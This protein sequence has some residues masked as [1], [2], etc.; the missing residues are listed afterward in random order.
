M[1]KEVINNVSTLTGRI[2]I[3]LMIIQ[4][5]YRKIGGYEG[6]QDYRE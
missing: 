5:R 3:E 6:T 1:N 4:A 2:L